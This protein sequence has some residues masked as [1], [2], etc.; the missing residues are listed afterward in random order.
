MGSAGWG[1]PPLNQTLPAHFPGPAHSPLS[2]ARLYRVN[3]T[4]GTAALTATLSYATRI[5]YSVALS[6]D[7]TILAVGEPEFGFND[8]G[9][10]KMFEYGTGSGWVQLPEQNEFYI[11]CRAII[12]IS[13]YSYQRMKSKRTAMPPRV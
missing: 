10:V 11:T 13:I 9:K 1:N 2:Q 6:A 8:K 5:V 4:A 3:A 7:G 12:P